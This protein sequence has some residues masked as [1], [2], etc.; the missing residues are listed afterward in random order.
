[1]QGSIKIKAGEKKMTDMTNYFNEEV[2]ENT[3]K[4]RRGLKRRGESTS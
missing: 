3:Q 1:M 4:S 2:K